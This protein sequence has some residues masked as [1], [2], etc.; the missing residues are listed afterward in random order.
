MLSY[1]IN[2]A[3]EEGLKNVEYLHSPYDRIAD[4]CREKKEKADFILL[5]VGI[6]RNH[7]ADAERGFSIKKDGP[8]DMRF[9]QSSGQ[10]AKELL[11]KVKAKK[12][13]ECLQVYG[14][15][16][17]KK[18]EQ[19]AL[20]LIR[21]HKKKTLET[22]MDLKASLSE[23]WIGERKCAVVFQVIRIVVNDELWHLE[24]FLAT[25]YDALTIWWR[26]AIITFHSVE[27][28]IVK[29][30]FKEQEEKNI[31]KRVNKKVI[32]PDWKEQKSNKASRSA[33]LRIVEKI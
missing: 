4:Y 16:W 13:Q 27:D 20:H 1:A 15:F 5:D 22:T 9:D 19:I 2:R 12:L 26:C 21:S 3:K 33:K 23:V 18:A 31:I 14:D 6:N 10:T 30:T 17:E 11:T 7:V 29:K 25:Y 8:L 32:I 24:R 28:R